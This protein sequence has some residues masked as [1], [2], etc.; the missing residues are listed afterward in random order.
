MQ[1]IQLNI[2][3]STMVIY[4]VKNCKNN[5]VKITF[6]YN[7]M[8]YYKAIKKINTSNKA[9]LLIYN[10]KLLKINKNIA[11]LNYIQIQNI[12]NAI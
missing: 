11:K 5:L 3:A 7:G 1:N 4:G 8:Q 10:T 6:K 12:I 9:Y 2:N